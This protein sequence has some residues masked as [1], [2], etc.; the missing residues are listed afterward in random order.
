MHL[1]QL[2]IPYKQFTAL[3]SPRIGVIQVM[4]RP[5][6]FSSV[7]SLND[8]PPILSHF[9]LRLSSFKEQVYVKAFQ[10]LPENVHFSSLVSAHLWPLTYG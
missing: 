3:V 6:G 8:Y 4:Q 7:A 2:A 10:T 5:Y 1:P 9:S